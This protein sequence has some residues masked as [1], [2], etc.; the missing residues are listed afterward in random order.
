MVNLK[1][2]DTLGGGIKKMFLLQR[3]RYFPMPNYDLSEQEKVKV[4]IIGKVIDENYTKLL[5]NK[6]GL[7]LKTVICL[8]KVQKKEKLTKEEFTL[9]KNQNFIEG[10]YPNLFVSAKIAATTGDKSTYIKYRAFDDE[11]YKNMIIAFIKKYGSA[12]RKELNGLLMDKLSD[13]LEEKQKMNKIHNLLYEMNNKDRTI[14]NAG[15]K[16]KS[17]WILI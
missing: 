11:H 12:S 16:R 7:N 15:S 3:Q 4:Q 6:T 9:L 5:I 8:D 10:R 1:M 2:I 13:A 17:K 14:R